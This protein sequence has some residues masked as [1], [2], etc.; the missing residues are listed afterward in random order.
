MSVAE[1]M[2]MFMAMFMAMATVTVKVMSITG[3]VSITLINVYMF[4]RVRHTG[5]D[6]HRHHE[7]LRRN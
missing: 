3:F 7:A 6:Q 4:S 2:A 5:R 1:A